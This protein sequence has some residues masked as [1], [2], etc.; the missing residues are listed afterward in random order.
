MQFH[1]VEDQ[2]TTHLVQVQWT[3]GKLEQHQEHDKEPA[4]Q[5]VVVKSKRKEVLPITYIC[6]G[7]LLIAS[8]A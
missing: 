5:R 4:K 7:I 2:D 8:A 3:P 1:Q 6:Y